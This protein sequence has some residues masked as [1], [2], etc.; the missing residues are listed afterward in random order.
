MAC[1]L[2][3]SSSASKKGRRQYSFRKPAS[4][5]TETAPQQRRIDTHG[6]MLCEF[7]LKE[8]KCSKNIINTAGKT[9]VWNLH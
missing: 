3:D 7:L 9:G 4:E 8:Q 6:L 2:H 5:S 1:F